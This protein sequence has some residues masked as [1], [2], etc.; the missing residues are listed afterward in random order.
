MVAII[1]NNRAKIKGLVFLLGLIPLL[2]LFLGV[3][4][5]S[6]GPDPA[7]A[8]SH[9]SGEW[10]LRFLMFTLAIT[11]LRLITRSSEWVHYRRMLGLFTFFYAVIHL[12]IYGLFLLGLQWQ[13]LW[14]DILER[15]YITVGF[16]AWLLMLPMAIT[17]TH[18]WQRQLGKR[19]VRLHQSI[20]AAS[21]LVLLH[22][23]WQARSDLAEPLVYALIFAIL[24]F[25]RI[26]PI[27]KRLFRR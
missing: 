4:Q 7:K 3:A 25:V 11:P 15:P 21:A 9:S 12:I 10:A 14:G 17:S 19:W 1:K 22:I 6:L 18:R 2:M 26:P 13:D 5:D 23:I 27:K 8:L 24:I 20:Y 16:L